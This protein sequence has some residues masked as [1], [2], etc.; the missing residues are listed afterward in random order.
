V[1]GILHT[2]IWLVRELQAVL[3]VLYL[4]SEEVEEEPLQRLHQV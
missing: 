3:G 4:G 1:D 2:N